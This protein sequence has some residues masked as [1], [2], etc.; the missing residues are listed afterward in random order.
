MSGSA[1]STWLMVTAGLEDD[2]E[3]RGARAAA[4]DELDGHVQVDLGM[5]RDLGGVVIVVAG[6]NQF[7]EAPADHRVGLGGDQGLQLGRAHRSSSCLKSWLFGSR[8][9][10]AHTIGKLTVAMI[11]PARLQAGTEPGRRVTSATTTS[12]SEAAASPSAT[13]QSRA[14][15]RA[16]SGSVG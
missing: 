5:M 9:F 4:T 6:T 16:E 7:L 15:R 13:N 10:A 11:T 14:L 12:H 1:R 3:R 2:A 8:R